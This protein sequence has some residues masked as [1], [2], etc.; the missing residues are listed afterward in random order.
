MV[1]LD[2]HERERAEHALGDAQRIDVAVQ[3]EAED[4]RDDDP[5]DGVVDDRRGEDDLADGA[6]Q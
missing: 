2:D 3:R 6:A 5:A 4:D 1:K